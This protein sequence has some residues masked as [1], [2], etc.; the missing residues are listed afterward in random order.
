MCVKTT[1]LKHDSFVAEGWSP[2]VSFQFHYVN[3]RAH[4]RCVCNVK[5]LGLEEWQCFTLSM[6]VALVLWRAGE[7][8]TWC[9][10]RQGRRREK[11]LTK[12]SF[13]H[14]E[15]RD[16]K[17]VQ[18]SGTVAYQ[19]FHHLKWNGS[20]MQRVCIVS[21]EWVKIVHRSG[22]IV[23]QNQVAWSWIV[24]AVPCSLL[25]LQSSIGFVFTGLQLITLRSCV[26]APK[27]CRMILPTLSPPKLLLSSWQRRSRHH[28]LHRSAQQRPRH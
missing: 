7:R 16:P 22:D 11:H 28:S 5:I 26:Q 15:N 18:V 12:H 2:K 20:R 8:R 10:Q 23:A 27:W 19:K 4:F 9:L 17:Y 3:I 14:I 24:A 1:S 13:V 21:R 25:W 6:T